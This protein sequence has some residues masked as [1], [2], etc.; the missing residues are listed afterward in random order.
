MK[1]VA[2]GAHP[3][4]AELGA[5]GTLAKHVANG[6]EVHLILTT[7]GGVV[8]PF[9]EREKEAR[10][11]ARILGIDNLRI[12]NF[13][14]Q[15]LNKPSLEFANLIKKLLAEIK[16]D[17]I[18]THT[19]FDYHQVHVA[20][21]GSVM[22]AAKET[23]QLLFFETI[24]STTTDFK[25]NAFVDITDYIDLKIKSLE[26]HETQS[27]RIFIQPNV[28]RSLANTRYV[29]SKVGKDPNGCAEG[30]VISKFIR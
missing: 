29:W 30:F 13:P 4:D 9:E 8:G 28:T 6:D 19:T 15:K 21:S 10:S 7:L 17:R 2:I 23:K 18:Y 26:I 5:G 22:L 27:N 25:P 20:V 1:I 12:L 14:V 24:S 11:A 3:D 16:P